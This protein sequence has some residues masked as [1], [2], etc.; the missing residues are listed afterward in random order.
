MPARTTYTAV[1]T[2]GDDGWFCAQVPEVPEAISQGRTLE[3]AR[4]NV[5][6]ALGLALEWRVAEGETPPE[7]VGVTVSQVTVS[8]SAA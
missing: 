5:E 7:P 3:E 4:A 6:E 8:S 2:E 1:I